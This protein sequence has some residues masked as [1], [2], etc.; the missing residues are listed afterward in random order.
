M[1]GTRARIRVDG[2]DREFEGLVR[3]VSSDEAF[4]PHFALT[5]HDRSQLV[6]LAEVDLVEPEARE[7]PA[8]VPVEARFDRPSGPAATASGG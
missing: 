2:R 3:W 1:P 7:L 8:G 6:Y 5:E 4:T